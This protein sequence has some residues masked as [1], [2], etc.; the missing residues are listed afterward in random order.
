MWPRFDSQTQLHTWAEFVGSLL[1]MD[2]FF[3]GYSSFP[4]SS[5]L[6]VDDLICVNLLISVYSVP[7]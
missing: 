7:N 5:R 3:S 6:T 1:C 2:R 4:L